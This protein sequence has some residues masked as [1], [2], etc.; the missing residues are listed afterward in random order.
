MLVVFASLPAYGHL[1]PMMPLA[2][3]CADAGHQV[4]VATGEPFVDRL[5]LPTFF[6]HPPDFGL[7]WAIAETSRRHPQLDGLQFATAMFADAAAGAV[8]STLLTVLETTGPDLVVYE[9]MNAGAG[10]A[11]D[12]LGIPAVAFSIGIASFV[13][14]LLHSE[15]VTYHSHLWAIRQRPVPARG[16]VLAEA[17]LEP[18]PPSLW[19]QPDPPLRRIP[20]RSVA[21]SETSEL[22]T[23]L[24][25]PGTRPRVYLT[26]GTVSFGAVETL[27]RAVADL[28]QLEVDVLVAVGPEGDPAALGEVPG[29][30]HLE[31]FVAQP[32]VLP[33]VDVVVHHG[34]T[35]TVLGALAAGVPQVIL[36]QGADQFFNAELISGLGAGRSLSNEEQRP[37]AIRDDVSAMLSGGRE[38]AVA[39]RL[40]DEIAAQPG[41]A[42]VVDE[43]VALAGR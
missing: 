19:Q 30:V 38:R 5:P 42:D 28:A 43:L 6:G 17:L 2:L 18:T 32:E 25:E 27:S 13:P 14:A 20:V 39:A 10:V 11:A 31:R 8:S 22:P 37:G 15:A 24:D 29:N 33:R 40:R 9:A 4:A 35:G 26:L 41:P 36:P 34:G 1:Y 21:Y 23:W 7:D 16:P 3:A 12:V